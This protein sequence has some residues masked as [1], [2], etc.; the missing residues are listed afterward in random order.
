MSAPSSKRLTSLC[1]LA[2][3]ILSYLPPYLGGL[4]P[5]AQGLYHPSPAARA[6]SCELLTRLAR[7]RSLGLKFVQSLPIFHRLSLARLEIDRSEGFKLAMQQQQQQ[8]QQ[9]SK[10]FDTVE[11]SQASGA[12]MAD[13]GSQR[14]PYPPRQQQQQQRSSLAS[15]GNVSY[16][17][18]ESP[19]PHPPSSYPRRD[20]RVMSRES[21]E[22]SE[23]R[24]TSSMLSS[25]SP[26][27]VGTLPTSSPSPAGGGGLDA[28]FKE[29]GLE[30]TGSRQSEV[31]ESSNRSISSLAG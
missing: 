5:V 13:D 28:A 4:T 18:E 24:R 6:S 22:S 10:G 26:P 21:W 8:Q 15:N 2:L 1:L 29:L 30:R 31:V 25:G 16:R 14:S 9:Q 23:R 3:Q 12:A 20:S 11:S 17:R 19:V 27:N 7:H